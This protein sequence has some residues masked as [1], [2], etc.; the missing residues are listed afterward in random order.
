MLVSPPNRQHTPLAFPLSHR[1]VKSYLN[2]IPV[3]DL[4]QAL[5]I[6]TVFSPTFHSQRSLPSQT[7]LGP[8]HDYVNILPKSNWCIASK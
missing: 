2:R 3:C 4:Y 5:L 1:K 8:F 7:Y 6:D